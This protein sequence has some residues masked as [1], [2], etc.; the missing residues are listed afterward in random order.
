[1]PKSSR[2]ALLASIASTIADYRQGEISTPDSDRVDKWIS[3]FGAAVQEPILDE[4]DHV[5]KKTYISKP[6]VE[7]FLTSLLTDSTLAGVNPCD[8]WKKANFLNIQGGG[9]SQREM[10]AM[11][12]DALQKTCGLTIDRCGSRGGPYIYLDDVIFTGNRIKNDLLDW[13]SSNAPAKG[14]V[15][16]VV[17]AFH[18]G[19]QYY[20]K[21]KIQEACTAASKVININWRS[22]LEIEDRKAY[23]NRSDVLRPASVPADALTKAYVQELKYAPV[24]RSGGERGEDESG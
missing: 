13:M 23:I 17:V 8:F 11:F 16:V 3:Q 21:T 1:M 14:E 9:N 12:G 24:L 22:C 19:G 18:R 5:L 20:A 15:H 2:N 4:L 6:E 7:K 10:L